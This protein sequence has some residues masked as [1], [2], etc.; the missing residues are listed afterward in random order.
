MCVD[1]IAMRWMRNMVSFGCYF[2]PF[3]MRLQRSIIDWLYAIMWCNFQ[4]YL[5]GWYQ[6]HFIR[7]CFYVN[8]AW[9]LPAT[10][11][12]LN[13]YWHKYVSIS[14]HYTTMGKVMLRH[15]ASSPRIRKI[16]MPISP[17]MSQT[18]TNGKSYGITIPEGPFSQL[19][20]AH[21]LKRS[22]FSNQHKDMRWYRYAN[23]KP[24]IVN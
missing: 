14:L 20:N 9:C 12:Y 22:S 3:L 1:N 24:F 17:C 5:T 7:N 4:T 2:E 18:Y 16:S 23:S 11:H 10:G 15:P 6:G 8:K 19:R 21:S 13:Q